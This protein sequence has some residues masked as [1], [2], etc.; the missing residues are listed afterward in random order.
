MISV[1]NNKEKKQWLTFFAA[2]ANRV[3]HCVAFSARAAGGVVPSRWPSAQEEEQERLGDE[4][5]LRDVRHLSRLVVRGGR[6][7]VLAGRWCIAEGRV[8]ETIKPPGD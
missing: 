6:S 2:A 1:Q 3:L 8:E 7:W 4:R 5:L